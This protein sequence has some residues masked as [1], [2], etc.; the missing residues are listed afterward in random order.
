MILIPLACVTLVN[1]CI[2]ILRRVRAGRHVLTRGEYD[3]LEYVTTFDMDSLRLSAFGGVD[4]KFVF[5][6]I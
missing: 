4:L 1:S 5:H 6:E 3:M 2:S